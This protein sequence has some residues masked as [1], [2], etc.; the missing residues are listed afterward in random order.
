M[1]GDQREYRKRALECIDL[2]HQAKSPEH[3]KML[4]DL[5]QVWVRLAVEIEKSYS[6][7][8]EAAERKS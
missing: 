8:D 5:A 3:K 6:L 1:P 4:S 2:A 7:I